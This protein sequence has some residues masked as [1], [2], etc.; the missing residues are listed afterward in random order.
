ML[1]AM[2]TGRVIWTV[3]LSL[4]ALGCAGTGVPREPTGDPHD[5]VRALPHGVTVR[6]LEVE[7]PDT[8]MVV[9][10]YRPPATFPGPLPVI[11]IGSAGAPLI[12]GMRL[13][14][15]D[16]A[17]HVP[18]ADHGYVVV[19]YSLDGAVDNPDSEGAIQDG[20][21]VF[22]R[23]HAGLDDAR[24]AL[25][26]ALASEPRADPARVYAVGHSSAAT[27]ALCVGVELPEIKAIVAFSPIT[28]VEARVAGFRQELR[29]IDRTAMAILRNSS[30]MV[31]V[32]E[33][34]TKPVFLFHS[35]TDESVPVAES[36][37]LA[38]AMKPLAEGSRVVIVPTG[39][40]YRSMLEQGIPAAMEWLDAAAGL[41]ATPDA[42]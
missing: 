38:E 25:K 39:D 26:I 7:R 15:G 5:V 16:R 12:W 34:R 14:E 13:G 19:A 18:W 33:L 24:R 6:E 10:I 30:P 20:I 28:D 17:E 35:T 40:H 29:A 9:W 1:G 37:R 36:T 3:A 4:A 2:A 27:L 11:L 23:A 31:H 42:R 22:L 41:R 21:R 8:S 32:A